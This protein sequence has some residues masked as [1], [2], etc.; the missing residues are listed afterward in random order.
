M[1]NFNLGSPYFSRHFFNYKHHLY[2]RPWNFFKS[3]T[4][5]GF[6]WGVG[7][8]QINGRHLFYSG[9]RG[10]CLLFVWLWEADHGQD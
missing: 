9:H 10:T 3:G 7:L 8:V 5:D 2:V 1:R 4:V 6:W